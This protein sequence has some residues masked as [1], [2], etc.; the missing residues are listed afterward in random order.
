MKKLYLIMKMYI[1]NIIQKCEIFENNKTDLINENQQNNSKIEELENEVISMR[2]KYKKMKD[3]WNSIS[4]Q[5][6]KH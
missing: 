3:L 4:P 2:E 1:R 6:Y 5:L